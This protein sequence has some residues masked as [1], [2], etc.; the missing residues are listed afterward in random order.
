M[1]YASP[2]GSIEPRVSVRAGNVVT[3]CDGEYRYGQG[4]VTLLITRVR[5]DISLWYDGAWVWIEGFPILGDGSEGPLRTVL[6]RVAA[7][8][9]LAA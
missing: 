3:L 7:L 8:R 9:P 4:P 2:Y 1:T 5:T 6:A